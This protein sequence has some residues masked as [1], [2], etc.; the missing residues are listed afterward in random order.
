VCEQDVGDKERKKKQKGGKGGGQN[1][2]KSCPKR[3]A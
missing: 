1:I 2:K 3:R